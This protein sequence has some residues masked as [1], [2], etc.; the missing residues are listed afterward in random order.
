MKGL[1]SNPSVDLR[2]DFEP[3][4]AAT[5]SLDREGPTKDYLFILVP[6]L[7]MLA[8]SSA[9]EPLRIANQLTRQRLYRWFT[10]SEDGLL[11]TCSNGIRITPDMALPDNVGA[12][13]TFICAGVDPTQTCSLKT[14]S[15]VRRQVRFGHPVG[16]ICTGAFHLARA[17]LLNKR[18]FTLHWEN[19]PAFC[20]LFPELV[21]SANLFEHDG[22]VMTCGGGAASTD[23][24]LN[25][26]ETDHG[27]ELAA[28]VADMCIHSRSQ[29]PDT[30]QQ[31]ANSAI[32]GTRNQKLL[33]TIEL[34]QL[35]IETPLTLTETADR[36]GC[37]RRQ[38][39]RLFRLHTKMTPAQ[40]YTNL[41]L[42][43]GHALLLE[44]D[45]PLYEI[46]LACGYS[47][48]S[49]TRKFR[50]K[51]LISPNN[52]RARWKPP[53]AASGSSSPESASEMY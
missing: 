29:R 51:F 12:A 28:L 16:G 6:K 3:R 42:D 44:T 49:F 22:P 34:M 41:R 43:R 46:A 35:N 47:S 26:I 21:P 39:E 7:T 38:M 50:E 48:R 4:G 14:L 10:A 30:P 37:S 32:L 8:L 31:S 11:V 1:A 52:Y 2:F 15:W 45:M 18:A 13:Y 19:Q 53:R 9:I 33:K 5:F 23:M 36:A 25:V 24:M 17:G 40:F 20:E 27:A